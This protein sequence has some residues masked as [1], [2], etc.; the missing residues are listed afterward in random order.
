M[1]CEFTRLRTPKTANNQRVRRHSVV[2]GVTVSAGITKARA[3]TMVV[4]RAGWVKYIHQES[5][6]ISTGLGAQK[7]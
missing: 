5:S 2:T 4:F 1:E 6:T 7:K 3:R